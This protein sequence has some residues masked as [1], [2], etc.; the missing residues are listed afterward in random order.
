MKK[1]FLVLIL[2]SNSV[3]AE[4][5][6]IGNERLKKLINQGFPIIDVRN[7]NE[8][9]KTGVISNSHLISMIDNTG[10]YSLEQW[11]QNFLNIKLKNNT[12]ILICAVGARSKYL[13]KILNRVNKNLVIYNL[14]KGIL[15]WIANKNHIIPYNKNNF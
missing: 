14:N 12:V 7:E 5:L 10:K 6:D 15:D 9:K 8:W 11:Y 3:G 13:A 2:L 4:I 1:I